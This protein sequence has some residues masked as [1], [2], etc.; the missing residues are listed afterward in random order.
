MGTL[1]WNYDL[2]LKN[3]IKGEDQCEAPIKPIMIKCAGEDR[4]ITIMSLIYLLSIHQL[5]IDIF[6]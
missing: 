3:I 4:L 6:G 1:V 2:C 5:T